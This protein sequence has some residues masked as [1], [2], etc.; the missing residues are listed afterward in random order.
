MG[1]R[2][3]AL[4]VNVLR[5]S[6]GKT[7]FWLVS[8][9]LAAI[10]VV[11]VFG[12]LA[13][14]TW[15]QPGVLFTVV[16]V[17]S[18][19][20]IAATTI[21]IAVADRREIAEFGLLGAALMAAAVL[22]MV[23]G[24]VTPGVL[25]DDTE[26]F[27]TAAVLAT[28]LVALVAAPLLRPDTGFGQW[29]ARRWRDWT[30]LAL[31]AL[32]V[33]GAV[34]VFFPDAIAIPG[35]SSP[36]TYVVAAAMVAVIGVL[37]HRQLHFYG[38]GR[39]RANLIAALSLAALACSAMLPVVATPY[40]AGFWW[41]HGIGLAGVMG[42]SIGLAVTKGLSTSTQEIL[43]PVLTRDPLVAFE[44][45]LSP[46]VHEFIA[47]LERKDRDV[48]DHTIRT[49]EMAL[50]VGERMRMDPN[51]LREL[52]LSAMLHDVGKLRIPAEVYNK[53]GRLS[54]DEYEIVKLHTVYGAD[55]LA[56]EPTLANTAAI[57]RSH[58]ERV[59][60]HGYPDGL[61]GAEIPLGSRIIAVC[62][63]FDAM[64]HDRPHRDAMPIAMANAVLREHAGSQW[65]ADVIEHAI[66]VLPSM[67]AFSPLD[68]VGRAAHLA[69][70]GAPQ[71]VRDTEPTLDPESVS[72]LLASVDAEI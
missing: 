50:R 55:M 64:T 19:V 62:D 56:A 54:D 10:T 67:L 68:V 65:D 34:I 58:H 16:L 60:G 25:Y 32:F 53:P 71:P 23:R 3:D 46:V 29:A 40:S 66:A 18:A 33:L 41:L 26:A 63:A 7:G 31:L 59:D 49:G 51:D 39:R 30:L 48:R 72:E 8:L 44:L 20:G 38:L 45:G 22:P 11:T 4:D 2:A 52:G 6:T 15:E 5:N 24:L 13:D 57:V 9:A 36:V 43:A 69:G 17:A 28:P 47:D 35:P 42:G 61:A 12:P 70:T 37:A 14:A 1:V 27:H 21:T